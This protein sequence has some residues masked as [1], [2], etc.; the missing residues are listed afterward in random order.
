MGDTLAKAQE[1]CAA[2][3]RE[4][5]PDRYFATL[6]A[7]A[8]TRPHLMALAA[9]SS[10]IARVREA[11]SS[12]MPG[13]IRLQWWRD[14]IEGVARGDVG[15]NPVALAF[16]ETIVRFRL[17]RSACLDLIDAR[18]FDLYDDPM[19]S[20]ADLDGYLGE[21]SSAQFRLASL[22]LAGGEDPGAADAA[23]H[24]GLAWGITGLLRALPWHAR[25]GQVYLPKDILARHGVTR[26]DIVLGR[27][28]PGF[29]AA[30]AD[31]RAL[32]REHLSQ[33]AALRDTIP[34]TIA[35]AF[36]P[37]ALVPAYLTEMEKPGYDAYRTLV[38]RPTWRKIAT[39]WW[40]ARRG[41]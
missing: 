24:A 33:V 36:L 29:V 7:P 11:V 17:P 1:H 3:V 18:V 13:E 2:L 15:G 31:M 14:V 19:P 12:P 10:E 32:A 41:R 37:L 9:F 23:G 25:N 35:P 21:T 22:I 27:G 30:L 40:A 26:D 8:E 34:A 20:Q 4:R 16:D 28:G 5:D 38:D 39:L 6:F